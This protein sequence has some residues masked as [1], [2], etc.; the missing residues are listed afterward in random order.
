MAYRCVKKELTQKA[1]GNFSGSFLNFMV[2]FGLFR[3]KQKGEALIK[4]AVIM[5]NSEKLQIFVK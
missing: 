3:E 1:A 2:F 5:E 4:K